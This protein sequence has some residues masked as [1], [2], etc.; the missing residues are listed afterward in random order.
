MAKQAFLSSWAYIWLARCVLLAIHH[1][2]LSGL[3]LSCGTKAGNACFVGP[4]PSNGLC[5]IRSWSLIK[6]MTKSSHSTWGLRASTLVINGVDMCKSAYAQYTRYKSYK[7]WLKHH[8]HISCLWYV[9]KMQ[10]NHAQSHVL[11]VGS[12]RKA[13]WLRGRPAEAT[14]RIW[15]QHPP[16]ALHDVAELPVGQARNKHWKRNM[17]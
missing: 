8:Q 5:V 14:T 17:Q 4:A 12:H 7:T 16:L 15:R 13:I 3:P 9:W 2:S 10:L 6:Y 11:A 1:H